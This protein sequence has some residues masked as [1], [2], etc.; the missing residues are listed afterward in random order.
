MKDF[1]KS[2]VCNTKAEAEKVGNFEDPKDAK[3][4][5]QMWERRKQDAKSWIDDANRKLRELHKDHGG[6]FGSLSESEKRSH[7]AE[8]QRHEDTIRKYQAEFEKYDNLIKQA[9]KS[10]WGNSK[11]GNADI[12]TDGNTWFVTTSDGKKEEFPSEREAEEY[13]KKIKAGNSRVGNGITK[14]GLGKYV[15]ADGHKAIVLG[16]KEERGPN[17][18]PF[19]WVTIRWVEGPWKG[20]SD[21]Y[22]DYD[23][24]KAG[25]KKV[26]NKRIKGNYVTIDTSTGRVTFDDFAGK[27]FDVSRIDSS[28]G[29]ELRVMQQQINDFKKALDEAKSL[30][31]QNG[32]I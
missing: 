23:L 14:F 19:G 7:K 16:E 28:A 15:I 6:A 31:K 8:A 9:Q 17:G 18:I 26:G 27:S 32:L 25:N 4:Y 11:C 3:R 22:Y 2:I 5:I 29:Y 1:A 24:K 12:T 10:T 20:Q 21:Q 30:A 13:V